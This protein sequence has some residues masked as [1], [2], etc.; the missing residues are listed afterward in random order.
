MSQK[1]EPRH[2]GD[3]ADDDDWADW[4]QKIIEESKK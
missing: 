2:L 1:L 3:G 4:T